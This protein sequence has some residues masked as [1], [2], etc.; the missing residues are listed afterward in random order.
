MAANRPNSHSSSSGL[1]GAR[2]PPICALRSADSRSI[3]SFGVTATSGALPTLLTGLG[4]AALRGCLGRTVRHLT[5]AVAVNGSPSFTAGRGSPPPA[6][7][8]GRRDG[9][10]DTIDRVID[11]MHRP[12][13]LFH[14]LRRRGPLN[15]PHRM[16]C[17]PHLTR[18]EQPRQQSHCRLLLRRP[19]RRA[20]H[21]T[22]ARP[23]QH[24]DTQYASNASMYTGPATH[25]HAASSQQPMPTGC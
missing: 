22:D 13:G 20:L 10:F 4:V 6:R 16:R 25:S 2:F 3:N 23:R 24:V 21:Q 9:P 5:T 19:D 17:P 14:D 12:P 18:H 7:A 1:C 11:R 8:Q 15:R